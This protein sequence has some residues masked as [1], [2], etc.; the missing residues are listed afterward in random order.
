MINAVKQTNEIGSD[1]CVL[2]DGYFNEKEIETK[3]KF[4][5]EISQEISIVKKDDKAELGLKDY[6]AKEYF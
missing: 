6:D 2:W 1:E 3:R 4:Y 5:R